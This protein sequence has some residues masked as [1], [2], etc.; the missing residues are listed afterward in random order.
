MTSFPGGG[1]KPSHGE[2]VYAFSSSNEAKLASASAAIT[3]QDEDAI[4]ELLT[5]A[6][7]VFVTTSVKR[8]EE[9]IVS[10]RALKRVS[11]T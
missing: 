6:S 7:S 10:I 1:V 8:G 3:T 9:R 2:R 11:G 5:K 4:K